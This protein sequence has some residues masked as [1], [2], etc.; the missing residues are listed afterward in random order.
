[1]SQKGRQAAAHFRHRSLWRDEMKS[2]VRK[3]I[4]VNGSTVFPPRDKR[5][6]IIS[7]ACFKPLPRYKFRF[8][9]FFSAFS[10]DERTYLSWC[11]GCFLISVVSF[12][13]RFR[14]ACPEKFS[15]H[16]S[17]QSIRGVNV[18]TVELPVDCKSKAND[19]VL[20]ACRSFKS[21]DVFRHDFPQFLVFKR[22]LKTAW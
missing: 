22:Q 16:F 6:N 17:K 9:D 19:V 11:W 13:N 2:V 12:R 3:Q 21:T 20:F 14:D 1:M 8:A 10:I 18:R 4:E 7:F 5:D 15:P